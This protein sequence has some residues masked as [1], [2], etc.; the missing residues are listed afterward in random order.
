MN[1][2]CTYQNTP[3]LSFACPQA[4]LNFNTLESHIITPIQPSH[5]A[6][7]ATHAFVSKIFPK[8]P[9]IFQIL[10]ILINTYPL[11][12]NYA[13]FM[14]PSESIRRKPLT[15]KVFLIE[16]PEHT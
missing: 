8:E 5:Y 11:I 15:L 4:K 12:P 14:Q 9:P 3:H 10:T 16:Q 7:T 13:H 6:K 2:L 1:Q